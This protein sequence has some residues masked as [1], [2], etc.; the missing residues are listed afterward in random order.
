M[1]ITITIIVLMFSFQLGFPQ[2]KSDKEDW[3]QLFNGKDLKDWNI[4]ITG[5]D[6]DD[7]V[8]NT[9][10]VEDGLL[11]VS[12]DQYEKFSNKFGHIY[13]KQPFSYY[14]L[15]IEY[16]FV[17]EQVKGGP[18]WNIRNSGVMLHS[19]A[20]ETLTKNQFFPVSLEFQFLGGLGKGPRS[21]GNL[22]TPGTY[23]QMEGKDTMAHCINSSS[24]TY[25]G[26]QWVTAEAMVMGDSVI[27]HII[28]E[29]TVLTYQH[30]RIGET[31]P[32]YKMAFLNDEWQKK[33]GTPLKEGYIAL[34]AESHPV[35]FRKVELLNLKG[36]MNQKCPEYKSYYIV[37]LDCDCKR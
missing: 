33:A 36:C 25:D 5:S 17:G 29:D 14:K 6:L 20:A 34:Q 24:K 11:K 21:T 19:Q 13:Y 2:N 10:R 8:G 1:K 7:N 26:N 31:D 28:E 27:H 16:R 3:L 9:F 30:P 12:Y 18:P 4:K 22:C 15:R 35:E 37:P 23:V 32:R